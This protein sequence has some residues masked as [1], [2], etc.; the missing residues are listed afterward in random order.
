VLGADEELVD[1]HRC[2]RLL[3]RDVA[4]GLSCDL[5]DEHGLPLQDTERPLVGSAVEAGKPEEERLVFGLEWTDGDADL[6]SDL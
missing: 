6:H 4:G 3:E 5:G 2:L 1:A